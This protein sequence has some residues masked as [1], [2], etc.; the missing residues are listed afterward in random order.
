M[1][2]KSLEIFLNFRVGLINSVSSY[3]FYAIFDAM[4]R[5]LMTLGQGFLRASRFIFVNIISLIL[6]AHS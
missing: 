2:L 4:R 5:L 3:I 6:R 1:W